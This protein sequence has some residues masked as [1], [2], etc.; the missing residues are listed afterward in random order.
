MGA[1]AGGIDRVLAWLKWPVAVA[2]LLF[3]PGLASGLY[4]MAGALQRD[5]RPSL[6][7]LAGAAAFFVV[8]YLLRGRALATFL[9]TLEHELTHALFA[10]ATFHRVVGFRASL[11]GGGH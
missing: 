6:P 11:R 1:L 4:R 10:W 3:L 8:W 9:V 2:G 5:P 7:F